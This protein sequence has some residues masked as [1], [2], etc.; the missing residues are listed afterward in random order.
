MAWTTISNLLVAVGAK[1]FAATVQ[2]LRDNPIAIAAGD[3]NA[4]KVVGA[5]LSAALAPVT[6]ASAVSPIGWTG[7]DRVKGILFHIGGTTSNSASQTFQMRFTNNN[8]SSWGAYQDLT[9]QTYQSTQVFPPMALY[10][11]LETGAGAFLRDSIGAAAGGAFP[12]AFTVPANC[13]GI[14]FRSS[15]GSIGGYYGFGQIVA[16]RTP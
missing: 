11:D 2:A 6:S 15:G 12:L 7:L 13:N 16:G 5:A 14:Q 1:P 8:G 4:P 3:A 9:A 10:V